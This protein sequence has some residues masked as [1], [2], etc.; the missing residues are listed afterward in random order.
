MNPVRDAASRV[1]A[2]AG[3]AVLNW[4]AHRRMRE[5]GLA[6]LFAGR[7]RDAIPPVWADL[8]FL[9]SAVRAKHPTMVLEF[10]SGCSTLVMAR[11]L[12]DNASDGGAPGRIVSLESDARWADVAARDVPAALRPYVSIVASAAIP[13]DYDGTRAWRYR[14]VPPVAP[15]LV[16]LDGPEFTP[17]RNVAVDVL[18]LESRLAPG[19]RVIVDGRGRNCEFLAGH[20]RRT[21]RRTGD[22]FLKRTVFE[23]DA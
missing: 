11:A 9:Y 1:Y 4:R 12:A 18:D 21:W 13:V 22:R 6:D 10:G 3:R 20:F 17:D 2:G 23:L 8:W 7:P 16:Y 14:D 15:E 5:L 19:T